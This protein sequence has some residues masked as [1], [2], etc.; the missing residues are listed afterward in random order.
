MAILE[1]KKYPD[2]ILRKKCEEV[3]EVTEEI[4]N[5]I[6]DMIEFVR[7]TPN[8]AG[9]AAPQI[10]VL[11]RIIVVETK[12]GP[13][14]FINPKI[15]KKTKETEFDWEGCFSIPGVFLKIKRW[16]G[17]EVEAL[18]KEGEKV[19]IKAVG[20]AA[21]IFQDEIDHLDGILIIDRIGFWQKL[22]LKL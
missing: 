8:A 14:A 6:E 9:L 18:N 17:I 22:K 13:K 3:K 16:K 4:K 19:K 1:I 5:L 20:L 12:E 21:R 7:K 2:P 15:V 10:G 11:K